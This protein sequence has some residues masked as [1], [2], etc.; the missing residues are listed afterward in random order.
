MTAAAPALGRRTRCLASAPRARLAS[1]ASRL[2]VDEPLA[3]V[4]ATLT[5]S[6]GTTVGTCD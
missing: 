6:S 4:A 3:A 2:V 5:S 1:A